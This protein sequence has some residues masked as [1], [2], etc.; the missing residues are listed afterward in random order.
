MGGG[1]G[2]GRGNDW[3]WGGGADWTGGG[4]FFQIQFSINSIIRESS[5]QD[6]I[7]V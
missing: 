1:W 7:D 6:S 2:G 3:I 5:I 4:G